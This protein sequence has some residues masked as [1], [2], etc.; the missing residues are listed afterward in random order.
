MILD[1][2]CIDSA[3]GVFCWF[4][5]LN[6]NVNDVRILTVLQCTTREMSIIHCTSK[7]GKV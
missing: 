7:N 1:D 4:D 2:S 5:Y 6:Q 3:F